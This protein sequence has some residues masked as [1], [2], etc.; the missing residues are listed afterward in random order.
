[1]RSFL[2]ALI[3]HVLKINLIEATKVY[4][5]LIKTTTVYI[6]VIKPE[7]ATE[8]VDD[9]LWKIIFTTW[10]LEDFNVNTHQAST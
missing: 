9:N 6:D 5:N 3:H 10:L 1:M 2:S 8:R 4:M 7:C